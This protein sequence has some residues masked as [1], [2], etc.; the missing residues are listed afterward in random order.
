MPAE[1][2]LSRVS[3]VLA[4]SGNRPP[5]DRERPFILHVGGN[6][7]YKNREGVLHMYRRLVDRL[8]AAPDLLMAGKPLT[9][10][11]AEWISD[12]GL[13]NRVISCPGI[14]NESLRALYSRASL[15]LFPS[16]AEGFGWPILEAQACGCPVVTAG[17]APMSEIGGSAAL[18]CNPRN[19]VEGAELMASVLSSSVA[20]RKQTR[21][22]GLENAGRFSTTQMIQSYR[23]LYQQLLA[24]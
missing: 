9:E 5:E 19:F 13:G 4:R 11:Q 12:R 24:K 18:Y 21:E 22:N 16:L 2:A 23:N 7:W 10:Q 20:W 1:E 14:D 15:L 17:R 8:P 6:Q 3:A